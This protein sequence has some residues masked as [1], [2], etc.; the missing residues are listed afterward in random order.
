M[1]LIWSGQDFLTISFCL[2]IIHMHYFCFA[3][4]KRVLPM[5]APIWIVKRWY[6]NFNKGVML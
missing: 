2:F 5:R 4:D 1:I 3:M 6:S